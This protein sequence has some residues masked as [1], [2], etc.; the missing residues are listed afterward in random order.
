MSPILRHA[1]SA[2]ALLAFANALELAS[3]AQSAPLAQS[4]GAASALA[5]SEVEFARGLAERW[6]FAELAQR[7]VDDL[8][9]QASAPRARAELE[10]LRC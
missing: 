3:A 7:V 6:G 9:P 8:E 1:A 5:P 2:A 4:H 10:L